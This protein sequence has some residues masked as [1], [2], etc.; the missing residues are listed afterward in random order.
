MIS[1]KYEF[2]EMTLVNKSKKPKEVA[3]TWNNCITFKQQNENEKGFREPQLGAL[4]AIKSHWTTSNQPCTVVMPTG[5]GKTETMI[6]TI[7]SE[8]IQRSLIIVP[9]KLLK[10]QT[11]DRFI[12]INELKNF[13]L[14]NKEID[15]PN[16]LSLDKTPKD[17]EKFKEAVK[18]SNIIITTMSL[19]IRFQAELL[20]ILVDNCD[21]LFVDEAHHLEAKCWNTIKSKFLE[22]KIVQFTA[23]PFRNDSIRLDG[24]IIYNYPLLKAQQN[25]YIQK[26]N[27][28]PIVE[29]NPHKS[30]E[31]IA[32]KAIKELEKDIQLG[33]RHI[34]LVRATTKVRAR[35]LFDEIYSRYKK[36]NP[37][38]ITS[39]TSK[40]DKKKY[41][42]MLRSYTSKIVICVDMFGEG[43]DIPNLKIAAVHDKYK[44][45]PITLQFIGRIIRVKE[46]IGNAKLITNIADEKISES[47][48]CLYSQD[49]DWNS[50][51]ASLSDTKIGKELDLQNFSIK[52][53]NFDKTNINIGNIRPKVS[54]NIFET[55]DSNWDIS[56]LKANLNKESSYISINEEDNVII[57][58]E[59]KISKVDWMIGDKLLGTE[60][61]LYIIFWDKETNLIYVNSTNRNHN[62]TL[63]SYLFLEFK[64]ICGERV[65]KSLKDINN[66]MLSTVGLSVKN[67]G[68]KILVKVATASAMM[69]IEA[70]SRW[71]DKKN[72]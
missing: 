30:D 66:L 64:P 70:I 51:L 27:F 40:S 12:K 68:K 50:L 10:T 26:I 25:N 46:K 55:E 43:I 8:N 47:L 5:T 6:S 60:Y 49:S 2:G 13:N 9:S 15:F 4:F 38:L 39:D 17:I 65:F 34:L 71:I 69:L 7:L 44:S 18:K 45:L 16:T 11:V 19:L 24:K 41:M 67:F 3:N 62:A 57:I 58:I 52:F 48:Q 61:D 36:W 29:F 33:Y 31:K 28:I 23:T 35:Y 14:I 21:H 63:L 54:V 56:L 22:K 37:V 32:E 59:R 1:I 72:T 20:K 53:D 42:E